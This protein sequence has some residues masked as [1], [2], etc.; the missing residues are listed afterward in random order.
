MH[1]TGNEALMKKLFS[2]KVPCYL[3]PILAGLNVHQSQPLV[4]VT[5]GHS[6]DHR[7]LWAGHVHR[8]LSPVQH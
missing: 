8:Q 4:I 1:E 7:A 3:L 2:E 5:L 6:V